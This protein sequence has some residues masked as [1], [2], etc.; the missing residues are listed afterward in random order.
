MSQPL[1]Y[2]AKNIAK[3]VAA[4]VLLPLFPHRG[5][6]G[7]DGDLDRVIRT[8]DQFGD[9]F[10]ALGAELTGLKVL[11]LGPGRTPDVMVAMVLAGAREAIGLD[12]HARLPD[13]WDRAARYGALAERLGHDQGRFS[14]VTGIDPRLVAQ[15]FA[16][17]GDDPT[18]LAFYTYSGD[19]IPLSDGEIDLI[20]SRAV[21]QH[22]HRRQISLLLHEM[23]RVLRPGGSMIHLIDLRDHMHINRDAVTGDWTDMLRYRPRTYAAMFSNRPTG[24]NRLRSLEWQGAFARAGFDLV[25]WEERRYELPPSFSRDRLQ[26]AWRSF[27]ASELA[28]GQLTT[29]LRRRT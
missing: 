3:N 16:I 8:L 10:E 18:R 1:L 17:I 13:E 27:S 2:I 7:L 22:V 6:F 23:H 20:I 4:P 26:R 25:L 12:T 19:A 5:S 11:E 24:V 28:V 29:A 15:Q 21:L 14:R 9:G